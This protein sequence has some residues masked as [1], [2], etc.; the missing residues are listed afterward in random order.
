MGIQH[1]ASRPPGRPA[2]TISSRL[3]LVRAWTAMLLHGTTTAG[4]QERLRPQPRGRDQAARGAPR[5]WPPAT[6]STIVPTFM[7]A[8]E[9][10]DEFRGRQRGLPRP[11]CSTR[12][13]PAVRVRAPGRVLRHFLRGGRVLPAMRR[14]VWPR[15]ARR[16]GFETQ[17]PR[18]RVRLQQAPPSWPP[19]LGAVSAEHLIAITDGGDRRAS[20]AS[21][22]GRVLLPGV[23]FF[24]MPRTSY[25]PARGRS[26]TPAASWPWASDFNPGSS[27]ISSHAVRLP[28]RRLPDRA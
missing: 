2:W 17:D 18:R 16:P 10:P 27:M 15:P 3:L 1:D 5:R 26:W 22:D 13:C 4:S 6:R 21:A 23:P 28:A 7:G 19:R 11:T 9:I 8:H 20:A 24:L 25:A 12:S 14:S